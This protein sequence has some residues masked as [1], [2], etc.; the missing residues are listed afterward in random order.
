MYLYSSIEDHYL[1]A[2]RKINENEFVFPITGLNIEKKLEIGKCIFLPK[3]KF[4]KG[5]YPAAKNSLCWITQYFRNVNTIA[6]VDTTSLN[7]DW[8]KYSDNGSIALQLLKQSIGAIYMALYSKAMRVDD[9][10]RIVISDLG[11]HEVD[12]GLNPCFTNHSIIRDNG[13]AK[14]LI[15]G[16]RDI[17]SIVDILLN[18]SKKMSQW[19]N[20]GNELNMKVLKCLELLYCLFNEIYSNERIL[21]ISAFLNFLF[22]EDDNYNIDSPVLLSR[23]IQ[24]FN[25]YNLNIYDKLP[26]EFAESFELPKKPIEKLQEIYND[27]R[28]R[29][30]HGKINVY[31]EFTV[32]NTVDYLLYK[33]TFLEFLKLLMFDS[34]MST[35]ESS[36][37]L[38]LFINEINK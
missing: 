26:E 13:A 10:R 3:D 14:K 11:Q 19:Y 8:Y 34:K 2:H 31:K 15:M 29:F 17:N 33:I 30:S 37:A 9:E 5:E 12:E 22:I 24:V 6:L 35:L 1:Y 21:K 23:I 4:L 28:N 32:I 36:K 18:I 16:S 7:E 27:V 38:N 20:K 25:K